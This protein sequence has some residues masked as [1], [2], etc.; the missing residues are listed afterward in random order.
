VQQRVRLH[1]DEHV[2][3]ITLAR[4]EKHNALDIP[5]FRAILAAAEQVTSEPGIRAVVLHGEGKSF[6]SGLDVAGL[7]SAGSG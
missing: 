2:A 4:P 1:V 6:C 7:M 5:M 3:T